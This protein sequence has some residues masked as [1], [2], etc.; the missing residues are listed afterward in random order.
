MLQF[1]T[2]RKVW[3][4]CTCT[5]T[6]HQLSLLPVPY[7]TC[8]WMRSFLSNS[9]QQVKLGENISSSRSTCIGFPQGWVLSP[10]LFSLCTNNLVGLIVDGNQSAYRRKIERMQH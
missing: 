5:Q 2:M 7:S 3:I 1:S 9:T 8:R 6:H 10:L 4:K